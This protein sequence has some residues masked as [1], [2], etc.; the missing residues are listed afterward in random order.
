VYKKGSDNRV[1]DALSRKTAHAS[2]RAT[3]SACTP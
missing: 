2:Q 3:V 1:A